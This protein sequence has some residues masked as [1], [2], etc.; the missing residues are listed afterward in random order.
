M[1]ELETLDTEVRAALGRRIKYAKFYEVSA[2]DGIP[3]IDFQIKGNHAFPKVDVHI[4]VNNFD[5]TK[6]DFIYKAGR[7]EGEK[8]IDIDKIDKVLRTYLANPKRPDWYGTD[9]DYNT[10][11]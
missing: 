10:V 11:S 1:V 2:S 3:R 9:K 7:L 8:T 4:S 5:D 6:L